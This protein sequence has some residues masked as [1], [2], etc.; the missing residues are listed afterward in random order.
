[1]LNQS[2]LFGRV[3]GQDSLT[4]PTGVDIDITRAAVDRDIDGSKGIKN[5]KDIE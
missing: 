2:H 1:M 3:K 4:I 5:S